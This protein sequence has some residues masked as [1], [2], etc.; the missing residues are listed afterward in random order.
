MCLVIFFLQCLIFLFIRS[1]MILDFD[2][3]YLQK[4]GR[5][6]YKN[7]SAAKGDIMGGILEEL[8]NNS[9]ITSDAVI[10]LKS[11]IA[12][13]NPGTT[14]SRRA[15]IFAD[16]L[17][18]AID[19][20]LPK[21]DKALVGKLKRC[22]FERVSKKSSFK[23]DCSDVFL[24]AVELNESGEQFFDEFDAWI[25]L[26]LSRN[27][28]RDQLTNI[29]LESHELITANPGMKTAEAISTA[30]AAADSRI[31][32]KPASID[33]VTVTAEQARRQMAASAAE[34]IN[35]AL[36]PYLVLAQFSDIFTKRNIRHDFRRFIGDWRRFS[37]AIAAA[38]ML[39]IAL[40]AGID[41]ITDIQAY[42]SAYLTEAGCPTGYSG[43][44]AQLADEAVAAGS[45]KITDTGSKREQNK[46]A[47][48]RVLRMKATAYDL[49][50][51]S[52]GKLP[53]EPGYGI[54]KSGSRAQTGRTVAVDPEVIPIGSRLRIT[55]PKEYSHLDGEYIAEDTG[56]LIKGNSVDI[57][58]G[59][60]T[61][62]H[63]DVN[64]AAMEF[65]VRYVDVK[66]LSDKT[67]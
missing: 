23:I 44:L 67:Y 53:G 51:A 56:R 20:R 40:V 61:K 28:P 38:A 22:V 63:T 43:G 16:A 6:R 4:H 1:C 41:R 30:E 62:G 7:N 15:V 12:G 66:I 65:G 11:Y 52:C 57:F 35:E 10:R 19:S 8:G 34:N 50:A 48:C 36:E 26:S 18:R 32:L 27:V 33:A 29:V 21:F 17:N 42:G 3:K 37:A 47:N 24:A 9:I 13:K 46:S 54:T 59:E 14:D 25:S 2:I 64:Q 58:F 39:I 49:S 31:L 55:F 5:G 45:N 60:D